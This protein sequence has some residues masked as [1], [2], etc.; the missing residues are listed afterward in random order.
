VLERR[1]ETVDSAEGFR[2]LVDTLSPAG[3]TA[4]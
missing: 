3:T 2:L 1:Y 4:A